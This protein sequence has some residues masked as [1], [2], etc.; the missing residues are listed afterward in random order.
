[1]DS[2]SLLPIFYS[3]EP[4]K[5]SYANCY[6]KNKINNTYGHY[7]TITLTMGIMGKYASPYMYVYFERGI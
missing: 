7:H 2:Q 1:M 3:A 5:D 4:K 6:V